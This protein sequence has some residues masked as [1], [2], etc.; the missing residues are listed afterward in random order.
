M[1]SKARTDRRSLLAT[2]VKANRYQSVTFREEPIINKIDE[3]QGQQSSQKNLFNFSVNFKDEILPGLTG[4]FT[5]FS[6]SNEPLKWSIIFVVLYLLIG[7]IIF[8]GF[9]GFTTIQALYFAIVTST[10]LGYGG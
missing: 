3:P 4:Q 7:V 6:E 10:T 2:S 1:V 8:H 5:S 9:E